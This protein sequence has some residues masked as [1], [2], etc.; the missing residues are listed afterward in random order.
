MYL[1]FFL[2]SFIHPFIHLGRSA[3]TISFIY[4]SFHLVC[5]AR[6][7]RCCW[8]IIHSFRFSQVVDCWDIHPF[9][10][11]FIHSFIH[12]FIQV[13]EPELSAEATAWPVPTH[14]G[15]G[16]NGLRGSRAQTQAHGHRTK[17]ALRGK[18]NLSFHCH[19]PGFLLHYKS[20]YQSGKIYSTYISSTH[21]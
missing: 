5:L 7:V 9:F 15:G 14:A 19:G 20:K 10:L 2:Y 3:R 13:V 17:A 16:R 6:I 18:K 21:R 1:I 11:S 12:S 4:S 8:D